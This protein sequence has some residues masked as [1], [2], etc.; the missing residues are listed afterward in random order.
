[1]AT[2]VT[3][4]RLSDSMEEG[5][6]LEWLVE[7][8]GEV[9]KG[10]PLVEIE[11]DKANM[12]YDADT[13]GVLIEVVAS[14]G[15]TLPIGEVIARIGEEGEK[16]SGD[17]ADSGEEEEEEG[18][19]DAE[20]AEG[21]QAGDEGEA[22]EDEG[23]EDGDGGE[24]G[25][26]HE[27][28]TASGGD[29]PVGGPGVSAA[30]GSG[31]GA[32]A[33]G[34]RVKAS[35]VARRM[36]QD[37]GVELAQLEGSGPGGRIVKAD[38]EAAAKGDGATK[39]APAEADGGAPEKEE[40]PAEAE[41]S[42]AEAKATEAGAKGEVET[43]E[44]SRLQKTVSRRMAESKATAPDYTLHMRVDMTLC[45]ELR[46]RLKEVEDPAPSFNDMIVKAA[47]NALREHPRVNGAYRDGK[48]EL[49]SNVNVGVAV[50]AQDSLVVPT[51]FEA[52]KKSLGEI[53]RQ[54]RA[55]IDKVREGKITPPE[56]SGGTFTV[57]N[58]GMYG[59]DEFS[60]V[61]NPPQAAI[62]TVGSLKKR[63]A[64]DEDGRVVA[65]DTLTLS[66]V[67]DHRILYGADAAQFLARVRELLEQPLALA[68]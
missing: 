5:T 54:A 16:P 39:E 17:S 59:V 6:I 26:R 42:K 13:S 50:A 20:A 64:V 60:A 32:S 63:P 66:L 44:L 62:L 61:I 19:G 30:R 68:L 7:E 15:D 10:E 18:E 4:P 55:L 35:P 3:M 48:F 49:Y 46:R 51:I 40:A 25:R 33:D 22:A 43:Q 67:S 58:L 14:E 24:P 47:A 37:L 31:N 12:T 36:A 38:V 53:A 1:V 34:D 29:N 27:P 9:K 11:T 41:P 65:R 56:V 45:V 57:S 28:A 21:D 8:G 52:D 23:Q 2:D